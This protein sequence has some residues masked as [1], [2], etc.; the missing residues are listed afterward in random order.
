M[1][2]V[3]KIKFTKEIV[4]PM[5]NVENLPLVPK[6]IQRESAS[7]NNS[8]ILVL[9]SM[10]GYAFSIIILGFS[11]AELLLCSYIHTYAYIPI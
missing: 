6:L 8:D 7:L 2:N 4:T 1:P 5:L 10:F 9:C 3:A 11:S